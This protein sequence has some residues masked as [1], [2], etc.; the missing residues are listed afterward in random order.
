SKSLIRLAGS[1]YGLNSHCPV[2]DKD[3]LNIK[4]Y[5]LLEHITNSSP[6]IIFRPKQLTIF[7]EIFIA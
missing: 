2:R 6:L 1:G 5:F 4:N 7:I 3:V